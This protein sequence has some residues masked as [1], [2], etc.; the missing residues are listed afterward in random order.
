MSD[1]INI[2]SL[3]G[4][5]T[6]TSREVAE[7]TGKLHKNVMADCKK[8]IHDLITDSSYLD[9]NNRERPQFE[10]TKRQTL[11]L[12][13][14]YSLALRIAVTDRWEELENQ[15]IQPQLPST[16]SEALRLLADSEDERQVLLLKAKED[17][18]KLQIYEDLI[19]SDELVSFDIACKAL[20]IG[21]RKLYEF[22]RENKIVSDQR[23]ERYNIPYQGFIDR[24]Y[25]EVKVKP[26]IN[27]FGD[28]G[29]KHTAY[30]TGA[31]MIWLEK[32]LNKNY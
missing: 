21:L 23:G 29:V 7:L 18:P 22:L 8:H 20:D 15:L 26:W 11:D 31:G 1:L 9:S 4:E 13:M 30:I 6:M 3:Q 32:Y 24:R 12:C 16:F 28:E 27:P 17:A 5:Q 2:A 25:F 14:G 19:D 10:L